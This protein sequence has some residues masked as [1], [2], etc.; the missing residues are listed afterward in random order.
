MN[1]WVEIINIEGLDYCLAYEESIEYMFDI[2]III[3][4]DF[5][6]TCISL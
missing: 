3:V 6:F 4:Y 2:L 1:W 5:C